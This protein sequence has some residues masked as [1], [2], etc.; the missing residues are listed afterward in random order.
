MSAY[1]FTPHNAQAPP[2]W[3]L[4]DLHTPIQPVTTVIDRARRLATV[5]APDREIVLPEVPVD[6]SPY[7]LLQQ[8]NAALA[9]SCQPF[10]AWRLEWVSR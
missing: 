1:L 6:E 5:K 4:Y 3:E 9:Q 7:S 8:V 2:G 10:V